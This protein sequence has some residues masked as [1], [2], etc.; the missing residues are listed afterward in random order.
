MIQRFPLF[1]WYLWISGALST[2]F[3]YIY[4]MK[5]PVAIQ[6]AKN[7]VLI[8]GLSIGFGLLFA[9]IFSGFRM[10]KLPRL[11]S[12]ALYSVSIGAIVWGG[13]E[14]ISRWVPRYWPW[15]VNP[16]RTFT[17]NFAFC[18]VYTLVSISAFNF[19]VLYPRGEAMTDWNGFIWS[20]LM[21]T[22]IAVIIT[23]IIFMYFFLKKFLSHWREGMQRE[24]QYKREVIMAQYEVLQS[25][26]NPHFLFNSLSVLTS[27][28]ETDQKAAVKF[29]GKLAEVYRYVLD[30]R[31]QDTVS[32]AD[33]LKLAG[34]Y[35][36][37]QQYRFN[38]QL[39]VS[40]NIKN[41]VGKIVPHSLQMLLENALKHNII[42]EDNP[43]RIEVYEEEGYVVCSNTYQPREVIE[44]STGTGLKNITGRYAVLT[45]KPV[46]S[47]I[48]GNSFVVR[49]PVIA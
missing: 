37:M 22:L 13:S 12:I 36:F 35:L 44:P 9:F 4:T 6:W 7:V 11:I 30:M 42:S 15:H 45:P 25:Q 10:F 28:V 16:G 32:L 38:E 19:A 49:I 18:I 43:L 2:P 27:L 23:I 31:D 3:Y 34:S 24:E 14:L 20:V 5:K 47:G 46:L 1:L 26:V 21:H 39:I 40:I 29:I 48:E 33:E 8:L 17:I 41:P